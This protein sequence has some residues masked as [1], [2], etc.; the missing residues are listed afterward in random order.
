LLRGMSIFLAPTI[1]A[2]AGGPLEELDLTN[3]RLVSLPA[4]IGGLANLRVLHLEGTG[5]TGLAPELRAC[6]ALR[7]ISIPYTLATEVKN[8][9]KD[10]LPKGR[11][12]RNYRSGTTWYERSDP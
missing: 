10:H 12:K 7:W 1:D 3:A 2:L 4:S 6:G 11:W 8:K 5:L 9:L